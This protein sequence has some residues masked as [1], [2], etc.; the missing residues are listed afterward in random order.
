MIHCRVI[1]PSYI[2]VPKIWVIMT[3]IF[4][5]I[6]F[7]FSQNF[8]NGLIKYKLW[9]VTL[10]TCVLFSLQQHTT[11]VIKCKQ[12]ND[13]HLSHN[14]LCLFPE[15]SKRLIKCKLWLTFFA[16]WRPRPW[17][18][19]WGR[20]PL[21]VFDKLLKFFGP[22]RRRRSCETV[23]RN[24]TK[25]AQVFRSRPETIFQKLLSEFNKNINPIKHASY[26]MTYNDN[27]NKCNGRLRLCMRI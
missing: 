9:L 17:T 8:Q 13:I 24:S 16:R 26:P 7:A 15:F 22:D 10:H 6:T 1:R 5:T 3:Y 20:E 4:G 25:P 27:D 19:H 11:M 2:F 14:N 23:R 18:R 21:K 12:D